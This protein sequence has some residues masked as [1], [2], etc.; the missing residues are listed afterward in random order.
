MDAAEE[1]A[2]GH[3]VLDVIDAFVGGG[4]AGAV[5]HPEEEAGDGLRD[6]GEDEHAA[7]DVAEAGA[8][9]NALEEGVVDE[10]AVAGAVVE[11]VEELVKHGDVCTITN[12]Q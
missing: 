11:P 8:A 3:F 2:A 5:G 12:D 10:P 7:G 1:P 6:E 9:G 4:A